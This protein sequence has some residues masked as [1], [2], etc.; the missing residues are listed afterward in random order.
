[1]PLYHIA[2]DSARTLGNF[3]SGGW[4]GRFVP[5]VPVLEQGVWNMWNN[6]V[7]GGESCKLLFYLYIIFYKK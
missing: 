4:W 2:Y 3:F 5:G 6:E 7:W 1:L